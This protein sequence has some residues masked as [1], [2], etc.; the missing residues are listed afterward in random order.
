MDIERLRSMAGGGLIPHIPRTHYI[1]NHIHTVHS[2]SPYT[3]A[4]AVYTAYVNGLCT[5]GIMDHDTTAGAAEFIEAGSI[6]GLPATCGVECRVDFSMTRL[7]G[8]RLNNP[9]QISVAYCAMHGIPHRNLDAVDAFFRPYR[10][11]REKRNRRMTENINRLSSSTGIVL[12][13]DT[14]IRPLSVTTVT[15]RH[16]LFG[17]VK[18]LTGR[19]PDPADL[20]AFLT[21]PMGIP[22]SRKAADA[23]LG[24]R[25]TPE[26]YEYDILGILKGNM[27]EKFYVDAAGELPALPD[28]IAM[29]REYRGI[30]A[31]AYLGDVGESVTGDKKAQKFEDGYLDLLFEELVSYG[32]DAVTFMPTRNTRAQLDRVMELC[33][34]H[35]LFQ[36]SGEDINSPRQ[37][38]VC[39]AYDDPAF[40]HL[41]DA[42]FT[43]IRYENTAGDDPEGARRLI[44]V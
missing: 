2:F 31:Y 24:G 16:L 7:C 12:D 32:F 17:L 40:A 5:A 36:I 27:V 26:Y 20:L 43:L 1:N 18:K 29:V 38:F 41:T 11:E 37:K 22:V 42:A 19:F 35:R 3:P 30:A 39:P 4:G 23:V 14:D 15:E 21:G 13:Y 33:A 8:R 34:K 6:L 44:T 9:D 25:Q 28:Y 10:A